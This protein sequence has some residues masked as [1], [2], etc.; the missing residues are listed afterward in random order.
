MR[1]VE[2]WT[3]YGKCAKTFAPMFGVVFC[4]QYYPFLHPDLHLKKYLRAVF[5]IEGVCWAIDCG[6]PIMIQRLL[7]QFRSVSILQCDIC[8][9]EVSLAQVEPKFLEFICYCGH[10]APIT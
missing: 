9:S 6:T 10:V 7:L 4:G 1:K 5:S 2:V 8:I 3:F